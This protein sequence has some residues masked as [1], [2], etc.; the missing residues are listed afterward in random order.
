MVARE[1]AHHGAATG[2]AGQVDR[3]VRRARTAVWGIWATG[4]FAVGL[5]FL[6]I[7]ATFSVDIPSRGFGFRGWVPIVAALWL[8]IGARIAARQPRISVGW[9]ILAAGWLWSV[10]AMFEEYATFAYHPQELDLPFVPHA[11]WFDSMVGTTVAGLGALAMLV[12]P[13]GRLKSRRWLPMAVAVVAVTIVGVIAL[14]VIPRRLVPFPFENPFG[15]EKLRAY[16]AVFPTVFRALDVAQGLE[17]LLPTGVLLLRLRDARGLQRRQLKWVVVAGTFTS[18]TVFLYA[19]VRDPIVQYAQIFG[20]IL[21]PLA[22]GVAMRRHRLY[23]IDRILDRTIVLGGATALLAG[24]YAASIGL[25]QRIFIALTGERSDAAVVLTTL[26]VAAAFTP[27]QDRIQSF[28]KRNFG[29]EI[30][31][32]KGL[33]AF[34]AEIEQH[35]RLS[36]RERLLSQLLAESVSSVDAVS[37]VLELPQDRPPVSLSTIGPWTGDAHCIIDVCE[38]DHVVAC[39]KLGPRANGQ[40][41]DDASR[42]KLRRAA[43]VV[44]LALERIGPSLR[45]APVGADAT[46]MGR[47]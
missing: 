32:T 23:D 2:E 43:R 6:F 21:V 8:T 47:V 14:A 31:G 37:G 26:L 4:V 33:D 22:F 35:L 11:V 36:D 27:L 29:S 41:Y 40:E 44:G 17:V 28:V 7:L 42:E 15:I 24:L 9:L 20:L 5:A 16:E 46:G 3:R 30:P 19:F 12:V 25:V 10:N 45:Y 18:V 38:G 34:T 1:V 13:D 39:V